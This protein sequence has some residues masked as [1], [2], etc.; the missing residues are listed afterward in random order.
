M[1]EVYT[2]T[3]MELSLRFVSAGK[4]CIFLESIA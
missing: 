3:A 2:P 1:I 4:G